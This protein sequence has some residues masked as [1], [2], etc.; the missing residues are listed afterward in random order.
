MFLKDKKGI[1]GQNGISLMYSHPDGL[2]VLFALLQT[3]DFIFSS[4]A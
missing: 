3:V 2:Q 1:D 4:H